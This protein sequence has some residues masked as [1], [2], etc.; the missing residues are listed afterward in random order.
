MMA[1]ETERCSPQNASSPGP[2]DCTQ[3][4]GTNGG[5]SSGYSSPT[6]IRSKSAFHQI[7]L[8]SQKYTE[9]CNNKTED[10]LPS[11]LPVFQH[12]PV[13]I[14]SPLQN[15]CPLTKDALDAESNNKD[16]N[17]SASNF[18]YPCHKLS[19]EFYISQI[20]NFQSL[21]FNPFMFPPARLPLKMQLY[22]TPNFN[23]S[24]SDYMLGLQNAKLM[25]EV[26]QLQQNNNNI[27]YPRK[28]NPD[29][30]EDGMMMSSMY[31][32]P[33]AASS[34]HCSRPSSP[35]SSV[36]SSSRY[37]GK[38][39]YVSSPPSSKGVPSRS[40]SPVHSCTSLPFSVDAILRPE[41]GKTGTIHT[42]I[43]S[44]KP[45]KRSSS[46]PSLSKKAKMQIVEKPPMDDSVSVTSTKDS[47]SP[48]PTTDY[49]DMGSDK[50]SDEQGD[51]DSNG[52]AWPAWVY[53]TRYSDRPSSGKLLQ[54]TE[55]IYIY[56]ILY[57]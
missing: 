51:K 44:A 32:S 37:Y 30:H 48:R 41:F 15:R 46:S 6:E 26:L 10:Q 43:A 1:L 47:M 4:P 9:E 39:N 36:N 12:K 38:N 57:I 29:E 50:G 42:P 19:P 23:F 24:A 28:I 27:I 11:D 31:A 52:K 3:N 16:I 53:C 7:T 22:N 18:P 20:P 55:T 17:D 13:G 2:N 45:C 14:C 54:F 8:L 5:S 49:E 25:C 56:S 40:P 33:V 21:P 35:C 34:D